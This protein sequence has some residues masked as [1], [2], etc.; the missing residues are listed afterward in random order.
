MS[1][2]SYP[3]G[4]KWAALE[5]KKKQSIN[6]SIYINEYKFKKIESNCNSSFTH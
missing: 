2:A 3:L 5:Q 6:K 4:L 1:K